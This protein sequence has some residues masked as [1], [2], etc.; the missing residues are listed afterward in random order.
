MLTK[1]CLLFL[2]LLNT[3]CLRSQVFRVDTFNN[4]K[5]I[6]ERFFLNKENEG[7]KVRNIKYSGLN[8][9]LGIY[10]YKSKLSDLSPYGI[11]LSS[12]NIYDALGPNNYTA[13]NENHTKGDNDLKSI[14]ND[15]IFDAAILEFDFISL[16]DSI[17]FVFQ[18]ASEEYPEYVKKG[19]SDIFGFFVTDYQTGKKQNIAFL[20]HKNIPITVDLI[21]N[22]TNA[23]YYISNNQFE[24]RYNINNA[25][26]DNQFH[27]NNYLFNFDGYT[28]PIYSGIRLKAYN[29]YH[30]K[31]AIADVGDRKF[32]SWIFLKGNSFTSSGKKIKPSTENIKS[33]FQ[34]IIKDSLA[35]FSMNNQTNIVAPIYFDFNSSVI[36]TSSIEIL[37]YLVALLKFTDYHLVINGYADESGTDDY[38]LKLSQQRADQVM[39][40]FIDNDIETDRLKAMG[41]GEIKFENNLDKSRKVEFILYNKGS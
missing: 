8:I 20:T 13:S 6:V 28:K 37:N 27:E 32:D 5:Q 15:K 29:W 11:I 24:Y 4:P 3:L 25:I 35:I 7:V 31:I 12:G 34:H 9:G 19:V 16:T 39:S 10:L 21:N 30:F 14:R 36:K 1:L 17:N 40:Y 2:F 38:N 33:Y 23:E 26:R 41:H 18:F 22:E